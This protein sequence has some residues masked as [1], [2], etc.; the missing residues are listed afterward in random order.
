MLCYRIHR[1]EDRKAMAEILNAEV[2][3]RCAIGNE[4]YLK[5][6]L[7]REERKMCGYGTMGGNVSGKG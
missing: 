6:G 5:K 4:G 7:R 2:R 3:E 1:K